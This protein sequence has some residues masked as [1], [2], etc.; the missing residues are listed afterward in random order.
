[1]AAA[2]EEV[3]GWAAAG[4]AATT[5][6]SAATSQTLSMPCG[7]FGVNMTLNYKPV[8]YASYDPRGMAVPS[9]SMMQQQASCHH[10]CN[11]VYAL[12]L[13]LHSGHQ[14]TLPR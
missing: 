6:A 14:Q 9:N 2:E 3:V 13:L 11:L 4:D 12:D 7:S 8:R 1:M 10:V 5:C